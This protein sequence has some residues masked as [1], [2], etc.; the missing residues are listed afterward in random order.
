MAAPTDAWALTESE[1]EVVIPDMVEV[2]AAGAAGGDPWALTE[3]SDG[4]AVGG[5]GDDESDGGDTHST[6]E[7]LGHAVF[8]DDTVDPLASIT[9]DSDGGVNPMFDF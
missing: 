2:K 7:E 1:S 9:S 6:V 3:S 4:G 8:A 5:M